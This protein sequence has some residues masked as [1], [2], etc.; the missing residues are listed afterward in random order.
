M[1]LSSDAEHFVSDYPW[2]SSKNGKG[3]L[4][5]TF[6]FSNDTDLWFYNSFFLHANNEPPLLLSKDDVI[7]FD[8]GKFVEIL[9]TPNVI[10]T[11][12]D[13]KTFDWQDRECF[14][15][16][17]KYLRFF[18][19]Y[20][21]RNCQIECFSNSSADVCGCVPF[22]VIRDDATPICE[23]LDY[24]CVIDLHDDM[25]LSKMHEKVRS[26]NCLPLCT[27]VSYD[28]EFIESRFANR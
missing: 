16:D 9:I 20:T 26:C 21:L 14:L 18:K 6:N 19:R 22:D 4:S 5:L 10:T 2:K 12:S 15:E 8:G 28:Y 1:I 17:E 25:R 3:S 7:E 23:L 11:D 27:S 13:L 24:P